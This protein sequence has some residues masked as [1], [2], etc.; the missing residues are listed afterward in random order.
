VIMV[1]TKMCEAAAASPDP[2]PLTVESWW[3][4]G[5]MRSPCTR[6]TALRLVPL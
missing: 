1:Q 4:L 2:S 3:G 6:P 5:C